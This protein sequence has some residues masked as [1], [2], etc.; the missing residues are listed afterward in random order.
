MYIDENQAAICFKIPRDLMSQW[1][2]YCNRHGYTQS[3]MIRMAL[4]WFIESDN[5]ASNEELAMG[6]R[7]V[8]Y[9]YNYNPRGLE[10]Q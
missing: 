2:G 3:R 9:G 4:G 5:T 8:D 10:E 6:A 7:L 1:I